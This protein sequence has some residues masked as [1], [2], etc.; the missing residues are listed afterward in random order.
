MF[1]KVY[2]R[3]MYVLL[4]LP[5]PGS[6]PALPIFVAERNYDMWKNIRTSTL[7][8]TGDNMMSLRVLCPMNLQAF[9]DYNPNGFYG[10]RIIFIYS[11]HT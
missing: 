6:I 1:D 10:K 7:M 5:N 4:L 9:T 8:A 2:S 11:S 3:P